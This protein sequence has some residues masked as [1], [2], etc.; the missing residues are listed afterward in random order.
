[1][2]AVHNSYSLSIGVSSYHRQVA[3]LK[4]VHSQQRPFKAVAAWALLTGMFSLQVI[5]FNE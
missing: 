2:H 3:L 1:M 4:D 5:N